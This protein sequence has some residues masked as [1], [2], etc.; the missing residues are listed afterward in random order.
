[1]EIALS[2][3]SGVLAALI[4]AFVF[5]FKLKGFVR[6]IINLIAGASLLAVLAVIGAIPF[7]AINAFTVGLLGVPGLIA[8]IIIVTFL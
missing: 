7:N 6:L 1:M 5:S 3:I 8:V 2:F 4:L